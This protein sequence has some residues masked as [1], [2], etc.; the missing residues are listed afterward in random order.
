MNSFL[1]RNYLGE[2]LKG[3]AAI[4]DIVS[5]SLK[6]PTTA[7]TATFNRPSVVLALLPCKERDGGLQ[8]KLWLRRLQSQLRRRRTSGTDLRV[9]AVFGCG[10]EVREQV[11]RI[12]KSGRNLLGVLAFNDRGSE[13]GG[14]QEEGENVVSM[15]SSTCDEQSQN[16]LKVIKLRRALMVSSRTTLLR[17][18]KKSN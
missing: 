7:T 5:S 15:R 11:S 4:R 18:E 14:N 1:F 3:A 13:V 6:P 10:A 12:A 2:K 17:K 9:V 8:A 16:L